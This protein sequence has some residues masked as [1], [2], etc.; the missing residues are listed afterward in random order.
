[1]AWLRMERFRRREEE[2]GGVET[3]QWLLGKTH[4]KVGLVF[5]GV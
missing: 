3:G 5:L 1:M 4:A 2:G